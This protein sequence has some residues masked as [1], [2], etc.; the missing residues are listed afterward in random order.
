MKGKSHYL[1]H[2]AALGLVEVT[3]ISSTFFQDP[4]STADGVAR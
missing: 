4:T 3:G 2:P 1:L